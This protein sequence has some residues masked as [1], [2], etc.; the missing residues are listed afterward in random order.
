[1][2]FLDDHSIDL[3]FTHNRTARTLVI[4]NP[5]ARISR[6]WVIDINT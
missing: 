5:V 3:Q 6:E 1:M 4:R 2:F